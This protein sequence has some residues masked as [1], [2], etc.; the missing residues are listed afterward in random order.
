MEQQI[1]TLLY[2]IA[3]IA[4][5]IVLIGVTVGV[6][7]IGIHFMKNTRKGLGSSCIVFSLIS[8]GMITLM[9]NKQFF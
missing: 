6:F 5:S 9:L 3:M 2:W 4:M 8:A 7:A 1:F